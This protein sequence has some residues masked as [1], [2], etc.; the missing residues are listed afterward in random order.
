ML[1]ADGGGVQ[2]TGVERTPPQCWRM[3]GVLREHFLNA[4]GREGCSE[5]AFSMLVDEAWYSDGV[6]A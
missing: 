4:S 3:G 6:L 1:V 5:D 2:R